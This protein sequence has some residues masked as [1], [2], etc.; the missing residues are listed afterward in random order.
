M[1]PPAL[2]PA[3]YKNLDR[4]TRML[5]NILYNYPTQQITDIGGLPVGKNLNLNGLSNPNNLTK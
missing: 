5:D 1:A 4:H 2:R 3:P